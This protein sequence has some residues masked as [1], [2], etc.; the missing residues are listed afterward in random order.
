MALARAARASIWA[1][2]VS[3]G[4]A[5]RVKHRHPGIR[6]ERRAGAGLHSG[7]HGVEVFWLAVADI[8]RGLGKVRDDVVALAGLEHGQ[9]DRRAVAGMRERSLQGRELMH[10]FRQRHCAHPAAPCRHGPRGP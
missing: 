5:G 2:S 7:E 10:E 1:F 6:N 4:K 8:E 3:G 9:V